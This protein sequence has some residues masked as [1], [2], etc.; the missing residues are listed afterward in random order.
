MTDKDK[1]LLAKSFD[2]RL[3]SAEQA[4]LSARLAESSELRAEH[5]QVRVLRTLVHS[6][7]L[8]EFSP[9]FAERVM[10]RIAAMESNKSELFI[11][12]HDFQLLFKSSRF[13]LFW[14]SRI[15]GLTS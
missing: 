12:Q 1:R 15:F 4:R 8:N 10:N 3:S 13:S 11:F 7:Q 2:G 6:A 9:W 5:D 14:E